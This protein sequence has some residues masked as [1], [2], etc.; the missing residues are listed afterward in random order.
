MLQPNLILLADDE[1]NDV[2]LVRRA[3][4]KA[5]VPHT[6]IVAENG[7]IAVDYLQKASLDEDG[8]AAPLP[9]LLLLDL[10]MPRMDG[11][12][13]L[14]WLSTRPDFNQVAVVVFSS[15]SLEQDIQ[16]AKALGADD[17]QIKP[18]RFDAL[19]ALAVELHSHWL[20]GTSQ[21]KS[22]KVTIEPAALLA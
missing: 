2:F 9:A 16:K 20:C 10:H 5:G 3:F 4:E 7:Q 8:E 14:T 22:A 18:S 15:S 11:F 21:A 19:V 6:L 13:V 17:Y 1:E 12:D